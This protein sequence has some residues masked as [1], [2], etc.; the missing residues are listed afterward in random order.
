MTISC[1]DRHN[2]L[3][4]GFLFISCVVLCLV[5]TV[6]VFSADYD[7]ID[8][9]NPFL[10][11]LSVA[12]PDFKPLEGLPVENEMAA[13]ASRLFNQF[14]DFTSFFE[15]IDPAAFLEDPRQ[16]GITSDEITFANW[17]AVGAE[18]LVTGGLR[19]DESSGLLQLELRLFDT[20]KEKLL[21]GK[22]YKGRAGDER[23]MVRRFAS[24]VIYALTGNWGIFDS[25]IAFVSDGTGHK[26]I[27]L[28]DFDGSTPRQWTQHN[29]ISLSPAWSS[30]GNWLAYTSYAK[31]NP[32]L[33]IKHIKEKRGI[34]LSKKGINTSPAWAPG[35]FALAAT[36]SF[37]GDPEIYLLTGNAKIIK[38]ITKKWG[39]DE[40]PT[41]SPDGRKIAFVSNRSGSP[42]IYIKTIDTGQVDRLTFLG[43]YNTQPSWS[44][45][46]DRIAFAGMKDGQINIYVIGTDG[47][48]LFQLTRDS[49]SNES[50]SWAPDGSLITF[51]S[52]REGVSRIFV[53]TAFG[54]DQRRLL[55]LSGKQFSPA[56]SP[57]V[58]IN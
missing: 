56:W 10:R 54:T 6:P 20:L 57:R 48:G 35:Q 30:D 19:Y 28:T 9:N 43:R 46:G 15:L 22:L 36:L 45:K 12:I 51:S 27:F 34:V 29:S 4:I 26:E 37:T 23:R 18:L 50:P 17:S 42:Q 14:L 58:V 44:P 40:S 33:F 47:K 16:S 24:E 3:K 55:L 13:E 25:R 32:D 39:I 41:W 1:M 38:R 7:Y 31:G 11:K 52:T 8:I 53:M 49:G 21:V 5:T 2:H